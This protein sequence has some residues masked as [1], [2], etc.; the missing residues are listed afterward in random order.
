[1]HRQ[2]LRNTRQSGMNDDVTREE[3]ER[4]GNRE[5]K[6]REF[7]RKTPSESERKI[8]T[9]KA[10]NSNEKAEDLKKL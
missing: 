7:W 1:M 8:Q 3:S 9:K 4:E 10:K 6:V 5:M 2:H